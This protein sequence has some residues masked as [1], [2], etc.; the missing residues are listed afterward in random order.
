MSY[1]HVYFFSMQLEVLT[2]NPPS[3]LSSE[4]LVSSHIPNESSSSSAYSRLQRV[5]DSFIVRL[6]EFVSE[7]EQ[8]GT[9]GRVCLPDLSDL[10]LLSIDPDRSN[11]ERVSG[12]ALLRFILQVKHVVRTSRVAVWIG[13]P[14][15][16]TSPHTLQKV[17]DLCDAY[18]AVESFVGQQ[19]SVP[20]EFKEFC[21]FFYIHKLSTLG[22]LCAFRAPGHKFGLKR[23]RRK[24][25]VEPLHLPPEESRAT[26]SATESD[27]SK[28]KQ[29]A[30]SSSSSSS[31][32]KGL[33]PVTENKVEAQRHNAGRPIGYEA[34]PLT[35]DASFSSPTQT[36]IIPGEVTRETQSLSGRT[37]AE[38]AAAIAAKLASNAPKGSSVSISSVNHKKNSSQKSSQ[39]SSLLCS[40]KSELNTADGE[41]DF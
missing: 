7:V 37:P 40:P 29:L 23:D 32:M 2:T 6:Q 14:P 18:F 31:A 9:A 24:L 21:G 10:L 26:A 16:Y 39:A 3:I 8:R 38:R 13:L 11:D 22:S 41:L 28:M 36:T 33:G 15:S 35:T 5:L 1:F 19:D 34:S 20:Y 17:S 12:R 27:A 4:N 30:M 25:H